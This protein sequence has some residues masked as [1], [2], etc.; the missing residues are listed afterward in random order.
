M[1]STPNSENTSY[2]ALFGMDPPSQDEARQHMTVLEARLQTQFDRRLSER[3]SQAEQSQ[4]LRSALH[5][6]WR[7]GGDL[8]SIAGA[9]HALR[10]AARRERI[11]PSAPRPRPVHEPAMRAAPH[12]TS[13]A[14]EW[15]PPYLWDWT[16]SAISGGPLS[17]SGLG[18]P[19]QVRL[20]TVDLTTGSMTM[21]A[22]T[23]GYDTP[24]PKASAASLVAGVGTFFRTQWDNAF[25]QIAS[26]LSVVDGWT[27]SCS[28]D[29]ATSDGWIG[30]Y[31]NE[32]DL[33]GNY[34]ATPVFQQFYLWNDYLWLGNQTDSTPEGGVSQLLYAFLTVDAS[35]LY[36][37]RILCGVDI[38]GAG[39]GAWFGSGA[40]AYLDVTVPF[41]WWEVMTAG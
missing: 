1:I 4:A 34:V 8:S 17:G 21:Y 27:V 15:T 19:G 31:V 20:P 35:H 41:I 7:T 9:W 13:L 16:W 3:V 24:N 29:G 30:W 28:C 25:L 40:S 10:P 32:F 23:D 11:A 37:I 22:D 36:E 18:A 26:N 14:G 2:K 39:E 12:P 38:N 6:A 5:D 33:A